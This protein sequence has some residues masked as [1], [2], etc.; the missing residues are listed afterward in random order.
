M[1]SM[2]DL[3]NHIIAVSNKKGKDITNLQLQKIAFFIFGFIVAEKGRKVAEEL[4]DLDFHRWSYGPVIEEIYFKYNHFGGRPIVEQ[5]V[6]EHE[7]FVP[8][9]DKIEKL[10]TVDPF[11]LVELTHQL[12]SWARFKEDILQRNFIPPYKVSEFEKEFRKDV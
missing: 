1:A 4:Y 8:F 6:N 11:K 7:L 9:N 12:P 3:S 2:L 5:E 10:L